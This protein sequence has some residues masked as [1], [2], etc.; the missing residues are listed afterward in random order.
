MADTIRKVDYW[1][2]MTADKPGEGARILD[3][4]REERVNLLAFHAFPAGGKSQLDL[5]PEDGEKLL[6]AAKRAGIQLSPKKTAFVVEGRDRMGACADF[7]T[8]L[9]EAKVNVT[10]CDAVIAGGGLYGALLWVGPE[11]AERAA[12]AL[13]AE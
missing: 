5:V 11:D 12:A 10:T 2:T 3:A 4:L 13:S 6:E 1:Y 8:K 9:A 7:L